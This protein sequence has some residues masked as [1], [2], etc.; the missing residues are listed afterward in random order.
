MT[1][2]TKQEDY[3]SISNFETKLTH[4]EV[5]QSSTL[6]NLDTQMMLWLIANYVDSF[7]EHRAKEPKV[8][9]DI[10]ACKL[11]C[12]I[13]VEQRWDQVFVLQI[14]SIYCPKLGISSLKQVIMCSSQNVM[15]F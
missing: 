12:T 7:R 11:C 5:S 4:A 10:L 14:T 9:K 15:P 3:T 8:D 13:S 6:V 2:V 1:A